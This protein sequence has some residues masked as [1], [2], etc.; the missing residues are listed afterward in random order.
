MVPPLRTGPWKLSDLSS[1]K[2]NGL[3]VFS[4]FHCGGGSSMGYKLS[5]FDVL[6]GVEIDQTIM[7]I[8][9]AN[10]N[11]KLSYLM[12]VERFNRIPADKLP[13]ELFDLDILDGSPP[14]SSFSTAGHR[15]KK[16]TKASKFREGQAEQ[17]LN[18][19]FFDFIKTAEKLKPKM[20]V[21]ENVKGLIKGNARGY[22]KE[23]FT[24]FHKAGYDCQLFLLNSSRMGVPQKRERTFFIARR[25]DLNLPP[26]SFSFSETPITFQKCGSEGR[27]LGA[28]HQRLWNNRIPSD[29]NLSDISMRMDGK[30]ANWSHKFLKTGLV[31]FTVAASCAA[32]LYDEPR[33]IND[34]EIIQI[35]TFPE[36]FN[37][38]KSTANYICGMSVP[39]FMMQRIAT[40][41]QKQCFNVVPI[42]LR[43]TGTR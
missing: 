24:A 41:I 16:W 20:V 11:P 35:Q 33:Y 7:E 22:V 4:C 18:D 5:G 21:A 13:P 19:L 27:Q 32:V 30:P 9:R 29:S 25:M 2:K 1:V 36:D 23:I 38:L 12:S 17:I 39:P 26:V 40:E 3:K 42:K 14:C 8:Y 15:E 37:F 28:A 31:P 34:A 10:H 6:G 43:K